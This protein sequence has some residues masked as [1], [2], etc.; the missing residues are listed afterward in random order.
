MKSAF[1]FFAFA[2][3]GLLHAQ[4][5]QLVTTYCAGC[6][7]DKVKSGGFS[8]TK[9]DLAHPEKASEQSEKV[10]RKL[11]A[12][13]MP[14]AGAPRPDAAALNGLAS[15]LE[16]GIDRAAAG[17]PY[18][19][20]PALHRLNRTEYRNSIRALLS[21]DVDV[22]ALLPADDMSHGF[23]NM[24]DVLGISPALMDGYIRAASKIAR[25]AMGDTEA[26]P[27][28]A[29]WQ[30]TKAVNQLRHVDGAPLGTRGGI[31]VVHNFPADGDYVIKTSFYYSIDGPLYGKSQGKTQQLEV[32]VNGERVALFDVDPLRT[33]WDDMQTPPVHIKAG[34][35]R[36][37]AA[38]LT[39]AEG[40]V[41][42]VVSPIEYTLVD[43]N[44]ADMAGLTVLPH[45]HDLAIAGPYQISGISETPSRKKI[46][47][48]QPSTPAEEMPC[49]RRIVSALARQAWRRPVTDSDLEDLLSLYQ[50]AKNQGGF[51][52]GI[53]MALQS[54]IASPEFV[55]RF[56]RMPEGTAP[57]AR[58]RISDLELASRLSYFLWSS[59]PD[60]RLLA[61]AVEGKLHEPAVL[62]RETRR[63]LSDPRAETLSTN[64]AAQWLHLQNLRDVQP[65]AYLY[66]NFAR[67][68]ADSMRRETEML[69]G[70]LIKEDRPVLDLLTADYS[71]VDELLAKHYGLPDVLGSRFRRVAIA[72][73][74]RRGLLGQAGILTL[75]SVS[76][77]TSPV[78][79][80]KY[81]MEVLLGTPPPAPPPNVPPL[82]E[83]APSG[84][85]RILSV[86]ERQEQHRTNEP[87][88]S[89][90]AAIDPIGFALENFDAIGGW[91]AND[92]G[93]AIDATGKLFDG[94]QLNGPMGLR[95]A[96]LSHKEAFIGTFTENFLAY[97]LGRVID[98]RDMPAVRG[99]EREAAKNENRMS[100]F[101]LGIV[102]ST[103]FQMSQAENTR[104]EARSTGN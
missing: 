28:V 67:N 65:D 8:W 15:A 77:R 104:V 45:L 84:D 7:N 80:G 25:L 12:G 53:R 35:Q 79:R 62:E 36:V 83:N 61:A 17:N 76:T 27:S 95:G 52:N 49:A 22:E 19:G 23:D 46:L 41:E 90:H 88:R 14:P 13:M 72:D 20:R 3:C 50:S 4:P 81:V 31:S 59:A 87:C 29:T 60:E 97:A 102:K 103:P 6:H 56:E 39:R 99:V 1:V 57:G 47:S 44:E 78:Q 43:L 40:P 92:S 24:S 93:F 86:R 9:I 69:F 94:T 63:M 5:Q 37:S 82:K 66:P 68:M 74:N 38:F 33:K 48:C 2:A 21:L 91:R 16:S 100:A 101:V 64:F 51:D 96:L 89:C 11:R 98:Y 34:P 71:F 73:E 75:T 70:S 18:A 55:F 58:W 30:L 32:S 42:D 10:I 85:G 26:A 54:V